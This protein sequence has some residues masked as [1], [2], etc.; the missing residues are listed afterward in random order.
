METDRNLNGIRFFEAPKIRES[1]LAIHAFCTR[2]GGVSQGSFWSLNFSKKTGDTEKDV[3]K[4]FEKLTDA[5]HISPSSLLTVNQV[6]KD[7][8]LVIKKMIPNYHPGRKL[9]YDAIITNQRR[10]FIG[11]LTADCLPIIL[12]DTEKKAVG[13]IHAGWRG[14][15][16]N[17]AHKT[18]SAIFDT[19]GT[20]PE[21]LLV[22]LG[23]AIGSCC[24]QV[25]SSVVNS[26]KSSLPNWELFIN[27]AKTQKW[28]LDLAAINLEQLMEAGIPRDNIHLTDL[29]T[30]CENKFFFSHRRDRGR[31]GRQLSFIGLI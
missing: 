27:P 28:S 23:P 16:L 7:Q 25:D 10:V 2:K 6:H 20:I 9:N 17:I 19:F 14:T 11:V 1:G 24:Y 13:V 31:T 4:N 18:V 8:V 22:G 15:S 29:C 3:G 30:A 26:F 5:F 21:N 12:L